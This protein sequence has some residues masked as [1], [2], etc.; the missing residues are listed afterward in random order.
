MSQEALAQLVIALAVLGGSWIVG[1]WLASFVSS[2]LER[3]G[4]DL[5]AR[6]LTVRLV[7]PLIVVV[8]VVAAFDT[9]EIDLTPVTAMLGAATLAVGVALQGTLSNVASGAMLWT[10]RPYTEGDFVSAAGH[11]GTVVDQGAFAVLIERPD[12]VLVTVPNNAAF[13]GPIQNFSRKGR[14]R[15]E[16]SV[17]LDPRADIDRARSVLTALLDADERLL[18][19][20][21]PP[22]LVLA[23]EDRGVRLTMRAWADAA[24]VGDVTD[25]LSTRALEALKQA[26]VAFATTAAR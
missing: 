26:D 1:S 14:R 4:L 15:A 13:A 9:L 7:Q 10:L 24:R 20:P 25:D 6:R 5:R 3:T 11:S 23:L 16:V 19:E 8:G 12:G 21:A 17:L 2:A 22:A 18:P